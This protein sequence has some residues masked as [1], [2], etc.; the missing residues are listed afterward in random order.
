MAQRVQVVLV[1][2]IDGGE[3]E[4]TISFGLDGVSYEIDLN[5]DNAGALRES[6]ATWVGHARKVSGRPGAGRAADRTPRA[7]APDSGDV[8]S[9]ARRNG[10]QVSERGRIAASISDAYRASGA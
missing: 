5:A 3:A 2:D 6:L 8:R 7:A 4:E 1:D 10:Y 9:W